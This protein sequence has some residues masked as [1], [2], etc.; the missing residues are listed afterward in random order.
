MPEMPSSGRS[1]TSDS[2]TPAF[3]RYFCPASSLNRRSRAM[4]AAS[5]MATT[6][7]VLRT[8]W[9]QGTC[10]SPMPS[11][12]CAPNPARSSVGHCRASEA[13]IFDAG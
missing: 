5:S 6:R 7:S 9:I 10:L 8:L 13:A 4:G 12:R 1:R 2:G 3:T 11:M